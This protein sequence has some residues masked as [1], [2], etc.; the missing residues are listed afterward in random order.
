MEGRECTFVNVMRLQR[1][2]FLVHDTKPT[3]KALWLA[4]GCRYPSCNYCWSF[5]VG[6]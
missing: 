4:V 6:D 2:S 3:R 5:A 1:M